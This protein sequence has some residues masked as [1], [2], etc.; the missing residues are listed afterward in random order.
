MGGD[1]INFSLSSISINFLD[2]FKMKIKIVFLLV[3]CLLTRSCINKDNTCLEASNNSEFQRV[4]D[5]LNLNFS[6]YISCEATEDTING[7]T[8]YG[9]TKR[10]SRGIFF[11]DSSNFRSLKIIKMI[12]KEEKNQDRFRSRSISCYEFKNSEEL[13][14]FKNFYP[15]MSRDM[16]HT[17]EGHKFYK[18]GNRWYLY[19]T[20]YL[21]HL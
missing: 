4:I 17:K 7:I 15:S 8:L 16:G 13:D 10:N 6:K 11:K 21:D 5:S 12:F 14:K 20:G 18:K 1:N 19:Y 2:I 3:I 9:I